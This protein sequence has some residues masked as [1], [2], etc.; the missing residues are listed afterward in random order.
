MNESRTLKRMLRVVDDADSSVVDH[1][2]AADGVTNIKRQLE[3]RIF[4]F[5]G[6]TRE[7]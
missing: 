6:A 1:R 2:L 5:A 4:G 3:T 7:I